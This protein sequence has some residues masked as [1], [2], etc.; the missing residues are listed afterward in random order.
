MKKIYLIAAFA[1]SG[2]TY[3]NAQQNVSLNNDGGPPDNSA[4][5]DVRNPNKGLLIPRILLTGTND[6]ATIPSPVV[7]L[8]VYNTNTTAGGTAVSP[9]Y[10]YWSGSGWLKINTGSSSGWLLTGNAGTDTTINFLGSTDNKPLQ[11]KLNNIRS[12][13]IGG[14]TNDGNV[15][16]GYQSGLGNSG[17]SNVGLGNKALFSN[18]TMSNLVAIGDSALYSNLNG[19]RN[20]AIGSKALYANTTGSRNTATGYQTLYYNIGGS[21]NSAHGYF[22]LNSNTTGSFNTAN[23]VSALFANTSG[24]NNVA[25]GVNALTFNNTG[26][27]NIA[28]G[29][30]SL[31]NNLTGNTNIAIGA[32]AL[33]INTYV[34]N[35]IAIGDSALY[36]NTDGPENTAVGSKTLYSNTNGGSNTA[37]GFYALKQNVSGSFNTAMGHFALPS[38]TGSHNTATGESALYLNIS[39]SD[40]TA[41]GADAL[42]NNIGGQYNTGIGRNALR[43]NIIGSNNTAIG[44]QSGVQFDGVDNTTAIGANATVNVSNKV[45]IGDGNVTVIE[46]QVAYSFPS[47]ARFKYNIQSNVPGLDFIKKLT[48]VTYYFDEQKLDEYTKTGILNNSFIKPALYTGEKQLHSGFLAQNV[49]KVAKELGYSFD[50][51]HSPAN[52]KDHYSLAYSQFIMPLVKGMQEQQQQIMELRK[53]NK[54][55]NISIEILQKKVAELNHYLRKSK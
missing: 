28:N 23:G 14:A 15:F 7:S 2:I 41:L 13:Y 26:S 11:F 40:N 35:L 46:G 38:N 4:M 25:N 21:Y 33:F 10:Y 27:N 31:Y 52:D 5:L 51:V 49:E 12:G 8:M 29:Y 42:R 1:A 43:L 39:G 34:S 22:S 45:R 24:N 6:I 37:F 16:W 17:Y 32:K 50:G 19:F 55:Q 53:Q 30:Q 47:D 3:T 36:N 48:P 54:V 20:T 18:P 44:S 9:G